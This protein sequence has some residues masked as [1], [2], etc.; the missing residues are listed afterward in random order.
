MAPSTTN[1]ATASRRI[2]SKK[3][4]T[5]RKKWYL[6][7]GV[8]DSIGRMDTDS[9][10]LPSD[11]ETLK[12]ALIIER[13]K[14]LEAAAELAIA[15]AKASQDMALIAHQK[16]RIARL[17]RQLYGQR[18]ERSA[19]LIEQSAFVFE[20]LRTEA[21]EDELAAEAAIARTTS[22]TAFTRQRPERNTFPEHLPRERVVID[23]PTTCECCGGNRLRKLG[24]DVTRTL[25][26]RPRQWKVIETVREKFTCRD[27]EKISQAPAPFHVVPRGWAGPSLLA[28][29]MFEKF[30]QHQP[31]NRQSER[32]ALEGVPIALSTMA[33]AMGS[34]CSALN[35]LRDLI[36]AHV[37]AAER[38][39]ADDTTVPVLAEGK[40]D[41]ARCWIYL[42]DDEHFGGTG[43]P[44]AIF[45][46][47]RDRKGEH[48]QAHL[49]GYTGILQADA[50]DGYGK[51]YVPGRMPGP[52]REAACWV[53]ARR[54]FFA[55][56]DIEEN[57]RRKA[58]GKREIPLSPIAIEIVRR[59]DAL[60][61]IERSINGKSPAE[62][63][64]VRQNLSRPLVEDLE[65][66][67][68]AQ[69][70]RLSRGHDLAK[71]INYILKRR[72]AFTLFLED[73]RVC[74]SNNAAE[75]GLRGIAL[76]RK[77]WLFCGSDRGGQRAAMMYSLIVTAKMNHVDPQAWLADVLSRIAAHPMHRLDELLP[78]NWRSRSSTAPAQAA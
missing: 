52:I 56:A 66:Y 5:E 55:M 54:P 12:A 73:G 63:L 23:P 47:S 49:A 31:L 32:Y 59:I 4:T 61:E 6:F 64:A 58:S 62:R 20:E 30:G 14:A 40:T 29:I 25:E 1:L 36:E 16:L 10:G 67:M 41:I 33:D 46:Y 68:R 27:C 72:A 77:S 7:G 78:W 18:S 34:V 39:H 38:L 8:C 3:I 60:F 26:A 76:G 17:E 13:A 70:D 2:G 35:P 69:L 45:H 51:L 71:A 65:V 37:M 19:R 74:L 53:H 28:M 44:A 75:R 50:Y 24:E 48:P 57:A 22:V 11:I 43:P 21:T 9:A 15:R 42:R